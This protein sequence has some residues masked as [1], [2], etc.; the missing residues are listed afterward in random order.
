MKFLVSQISYF[1]KIRDFRRNISGLVKYIVFLLAIIL[2]FTVVFHFLMLYAEG[3]EFS[4]ISGLYWTLTVMTTLGF[5]DITFE[6]D[7]G[8]AFSVL[9][10]VSGVILL[11]I[12]LP[13]TFIRTFYAPWLEA[14]LHARC[15]REVDPETSGHIIICNYETIAL[16]LIKKL[17]QRNIKYFIVESD[18]S[19]AT[20]FFHDGLSVINGSIESVETFRKM[21]A[22]KARMI[23]ANC[24]D[25]TN[26]NVILT[27]RECAPETPIVALAEADDSIDILE[28]SG[29]TN[30]LPLKRILGQ[31]LANR[32][33]LGGSSTNRIGSLNGFEVFEFSVCGEPFSGKSLVESR[34]RETLGINIIGIWE[35][36]VLVRAQPDSVLTD[37]CVAVGIGTRQQVEE[38][39]KLLGADQSS[40]GGSVLIIGG[41]KVGL[42]SA[43]SLKS[44]GIEVMMVEQDPTLASVIGSVP[45]RLTIGNAA[46]RQTLETGGLK[47]ASLV[48]LS[49]NSDAI[50]IYLAVYCRRLRPDMRIVSRVTHERN[51]EAIHRAGADFVLSYAPIGAEY[52]LSLIERRDPVILG[53]NIELFIIDT[54]EK[55]VGQ[56]LA[57]SRIGALTGLI[58][59]AVEKEDETKLA[60]DPNLRPEPGSR[61]HL[62]GNKDQLA[63]FRDRFE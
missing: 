19:R 44:N 23:F 40:R 57:E 9:V 42:A 55:L 37:E 8:R 32:I 46:D 63:E 16:E 17:D 5:G 56:T 59:L 20:E 49:T 11:L 61:L 3:R 58:V 54:P 7:I 47:E 22:S 18:A 15:P 53:E 36:G 4:W 45:D 10:L 38:L 13:F 24:D 2:V 48:I 34:F 33:N 62:L 43:E 12:M 41:G 28:L 21:N 6:S 50:N 30:V 14:Q 1:I 39:G 31:K 27:V 25:A 35:R 60:T 52:V 29:A 26:T 51:L